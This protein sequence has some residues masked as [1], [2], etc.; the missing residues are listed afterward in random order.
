MKKYCGR[1]EIYT[2][3]NLCTRYK[4]EVLLAVIPVSLWKVSV[5]FERAAKPA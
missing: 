3:V 1:R 5:Y 4:C 2:F